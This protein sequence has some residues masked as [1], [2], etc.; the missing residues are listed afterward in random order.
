MTSSLRIAILSYKMATIPL[1]LSVLAFIFVVG[2][3]LM[4]YGML[5]APEGYEDERGF[6]S[7]KEPSAAVRGRDEG[8]VTP[9]ESSAFHGK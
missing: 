4:I 7:Q 1:L 9:G 8:M 2:V 6:H 3:A 5:T